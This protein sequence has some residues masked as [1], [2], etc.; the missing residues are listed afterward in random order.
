[1]LDILITYNL[2]VLTYEGYFYGLHITNYFDQ[3]MES[4]RD[5]CRAIILYKFLGELTQ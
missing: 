4:N 1:M 3:K 5:Q 2:E